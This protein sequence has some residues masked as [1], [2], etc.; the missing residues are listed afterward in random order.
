[1]ARTAPALAVVL[2]GL[3]LLLPGPATAAETGL[4]G[5][6]K[7]TVLDQ[8]EQPTL[9]ILTFENKDGKW[10]GSVSA[11][12]E[13]VPEAEVNE[14]TLTGDKLF[15]SLKVGDNSFFSF[16]GRMPAQAGGAIRGSFNIGRNLFP[17]HLE[18]TK[19]STLDPYELNKEVVARGGDD[20]RFFNAVVSLL[21]AAEEKKAKP[22][23][24]RGWA[25]KAVKNAEAWGPRWQRH[26]AMR[27][28]QALAA[29]EGQAA[30]AVN[31][32]RRAERLLEARDTPGTR[33]NVLSVLASALKKQGKAEELK[34][35]ETK[36]D[37]TDILPKPTKFEGRKAKSDRAVLVELFTGAQCP[38][39]VG[40]GLALDGL[41]KTYKPN[42]LVVLNYHLHGNGPDPM[43]NQDTFDRAEAYGEMVE[44][45]PTVVL[46]GRPLS[47][48]A[49][50]IDDAPDLYRGIR[51]L[52]DPRLEET[53]KATLKVSASQKGTKISISTQVSDL[54]RTGEGVRLKVALVEPEV[55]YVGGN[56]MRVHHQVVRAMP[57]G[58][59]GVALAEKSAKKDFSVDLE[60]LRGKINKYLDDFAK[61]AE[62]KFPS[63]ERPMDFRN[64]KVVAFI[65]DDQNF[66]VL[67][68]VQADVRT[69]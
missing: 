29:Q 20:L 24:I 47:R 38:T 6:W 49:G 28:A 63:P 27:V 11:N 68:A 52:I 51:K 26:Q 58:V 2:L 56:K 14:I 66:E 25:E 67:Q 18:T 19:L 31:Y 16:E 37:Q 30:L 61:K 69:E 55:R 53:S 64:L 54:V 45:T 34:D 1:M 4:A 35:I 21:N 9:Y 22:E 59:K 17:A 50:A 39:C 46:N 44:A 10:V 60:E 5:N 40:A 13:E 3:L 48:F 33:F 42:E 41:L 23:E 62:V 12:S 8:G 43:T 15:V 32:A 57:A 36:L 7:V 65:Q